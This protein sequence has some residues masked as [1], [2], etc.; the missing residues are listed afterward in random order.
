VDKTRSIDFATITLRDALD[1]AAI[2]EEEAR[3]RYEEFADQ[4]VLHHNPEAA[5]FFRFM[6]AVEQKHEDKLNEQRKELFGD[7]P[8]VVRREMIFDIEAPEYDDVRANMTLLQALETSLHAEEKA[9]AFFDA[10]VK[11]VK[12]AKV[13]ELFLHLRDEEAEHQALVKKEIAKLPPEVKG[14]ITADDV[15]DEPVAL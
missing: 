14:A 5:R 7:Q 10:A 9:Y 12:D 15:D 8:R 4:M 2:V 3:D 1:L 6:L 13:K 11:E